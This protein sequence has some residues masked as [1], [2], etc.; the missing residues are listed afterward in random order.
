MNMELLDTS[1][2]ILGSWCAIRNS[3]GENRYEW[4][5]LG[6][7]FTMLSSLPTIS[8]LMNKDLNRQT[9]LRSLFTYAGLATGITLM[10]N[11]IT[12]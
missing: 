9:K 7:I 8:K 12:Q 1:V 6:F 4:L 11:A 10:M 5:T 3:N 2:C